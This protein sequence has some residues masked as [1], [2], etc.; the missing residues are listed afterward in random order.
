MGTAPLITDGAIAIRIHWRR[1]AKVMLDEDLAGLYDVPTKSLNE[2]VKRNLERFPAEFMLALAEEKRDSLRS[3]FATS[4][5]GRGGRA[6][7]PWSFTEHGVLMH[8]NVLHSKRAIAASIR[9]IRVL[10]RMNRILTNDREL[11]DTVKHLTEKPAG[12]R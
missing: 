12:S 10:V 3:Q 11:F 1:G 7:H 4:M 5:K 6:I 2:Q 9:I 8:S